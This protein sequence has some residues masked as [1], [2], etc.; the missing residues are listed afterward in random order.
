MGWADG[1]LVTVIK[2]FHANYPGFEGFRQGTTDAHLSR[3][4]ANGQLTHSLGGY[5]PVPT[6]GYN[7]FTPR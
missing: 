3:D 5:C 6:Y 4:I 1:V 2:N 7:R